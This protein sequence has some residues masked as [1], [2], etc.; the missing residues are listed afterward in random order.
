MD[1]NQGNFLA[2][3]VKAGKTQQVPI[4]FQGLS[5]CAD[6]VLL[7]IWFSTYEYQS[8]KFPGS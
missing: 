6:G 1:T 8:R 5:A 4:L 3:S 7:S 2:H